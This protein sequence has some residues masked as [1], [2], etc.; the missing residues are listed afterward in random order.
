MYMYMKNLTPALVGGR[1]EYI[2]ML[3]SFHFVWI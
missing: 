1:N 2:A 3:V